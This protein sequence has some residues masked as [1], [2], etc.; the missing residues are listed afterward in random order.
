VIGLLRIAPWR[1]A[2]GLLLRRPGVAVALIAAAFVATLPASAAAP[3][4]S[5]AR[6]AAVREHLRLAG[7]LRGVAPD[8]ADHDALLDRLGLAGR[9]DHLPRQLSGGE[10]QRVAIAFNALGPPALLVADEPTGQLDTP[11]WTACWTHSG[12]SP[13][14]GWPS[15]PPPTIRP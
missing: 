10:Q 7:Q 4:L 14:P 11:Q 13:R 5:S 1:R 6:S 9:A 12:P 3:F 15:S 2:P 8:G